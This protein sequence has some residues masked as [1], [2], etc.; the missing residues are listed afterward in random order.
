MKKT[1]LAVAAV[2]LFA[3]STPIY[4]QQMTTKQLLV[5]AQHSPARALPRTAFLGDVAAH[6]GKESTLGR[7]AA[8]T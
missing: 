4:A 7:E 5:G 1:L 6:A 2:A 8:R 3:T